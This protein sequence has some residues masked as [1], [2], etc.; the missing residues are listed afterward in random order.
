MTPVEVVRDLR[1]AGWDVRLY[2]GRLIARPPDGA[3][4][5]G[6][7]ISSL[8]SVRDGVLSLLAAERLVPPEG[9][10][11]VADALASG[12]TPTS[13]RPWGDADQEWYES[14]WQ[15]DEWPELVGDLP[16]D[17]IL[18]TGR[19]QL[20]GTTKAPVAR[21]R[22]PRKRGE[23]EGDTLMLCLRHARR[24]ALWARRPP[25]PVD[26]DACPWH[27]SPNAFCHMCAG[28]VM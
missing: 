10:Q 4:D 13:V 23:P 27:S 18:K 12:W 20:C 2:D 15:P 8:S 24:W 11:A 7:G 22:K 28:R 14:E 26:P 25:A 5:V 1:A 19:C 21:Y 17:R 16:V 3:A 6:A 9:H